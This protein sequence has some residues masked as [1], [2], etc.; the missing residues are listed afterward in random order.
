MK[1]FTPIYAHPTITGATFNNV[2]IEDTKTTETDDNYIEIEFTMSVDKRI[3]GKSKLAFYGMNNSPDNTNAPVL[4]RFKNPN[5]KAEKEGE[6]Q[7]EPEFL[8]D[9]LYDENFNV[10]KNIP[11]EYQV[12]DYGFLS[13][14]NFKI[15]CKTIGNTRKIDQ[16]AQ[17]HQ[18]MILQKLLFF[19][20]EVGVQFKFIT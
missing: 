7:L 16:P 10:N 9:K 15:V 12:T 18:G 4:V 1:L 14:E 20:E 13:F 6:P 5:F 2:T 8:T 3:I 19:N 11:K 17:A